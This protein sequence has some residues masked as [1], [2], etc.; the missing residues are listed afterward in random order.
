MHIVSGYI[1]REGEREGGTKKGTRT[2]WPAGL[3]G[4]PGTGEETILP[5][6]PGT[7]IGSPAQGCHLPQSSWPHHQLLDRA[8]SLVVFMLERVED[9][10]RARSKGREGKRTVVLEF[11]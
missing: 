4:Y 3:R 8:F 2:L 7:W 5:D 11:L 1:G 9:G 6:T 10:A